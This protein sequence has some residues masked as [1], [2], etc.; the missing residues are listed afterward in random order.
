MSSLAMHQFLT[1]YEARPHKIR[2][3]TE[4]AESGSGKADPSTT[5]QSGNGATDGAF[6][7]PDNE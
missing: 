2:T 6:G 1:L 5:S 7:P 4:T 3:R